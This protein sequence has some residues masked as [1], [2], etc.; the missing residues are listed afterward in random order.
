MASASAGVERE[1]TIAGAIRGLARDRSGKPLGTIYCAHPATPFPYDQPWGVQ[2]RSGTQK[3]CPG[4][5][6][7][8][9]QVDFRLPCPMVGS[10]AS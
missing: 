1:S 6:V 2:F 5:T 9:D 10:L 4:R 8:R 3:L 7:V